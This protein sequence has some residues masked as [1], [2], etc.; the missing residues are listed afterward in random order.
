MKTI[1]ERWKGQTEKEKE[2]QPPPPPQPPGIISRR[3]PV[4]SSDKNGKMH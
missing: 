3:H 4:T 2:L 1:E